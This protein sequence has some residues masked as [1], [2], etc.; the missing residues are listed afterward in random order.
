MAI[1]FCLPSDE[2]TEDHYRRLEQLL[3]DIYE[4]MRI[5][6]TKQHPHLAVQA[7]FRKYPSLIAYHSN[8]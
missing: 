6:L 2:E 5:I 4:V 1:P 3:A 7:N 8:K